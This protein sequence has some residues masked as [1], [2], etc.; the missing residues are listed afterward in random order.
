MN[1]ESQ[2]RTIFLQGIT[3]RHF[4][5]DHIIYWQRFFICQQ[6]TTDE[7]ENENLYLKDGWL[8]KY[9]IMN[10]MK[11]LEAAEVLSQQ[12]N[13]KKLVFQKRVLEYYL[14]N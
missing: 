6:S 4:E 10:P 9:K 11:G 3:C 7:I 1:W 12:L 5:S 13:D 2:N 14:N 8:E